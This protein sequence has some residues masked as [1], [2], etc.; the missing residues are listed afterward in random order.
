MFSYWRPPEQNQGVGIAFT[1]RFGGFSRGT[2]A[3]LNL[4]RTDVDDP[5][6]VAAS[7]RE[8]TAAIGVDHV[9]TARQTHSTIVYP[10]A[11]PQDWPP[12]AELGSSLPGGRRLPEADALIT[13]APGV[14][15]CIRVADCVP[16]LLADSQARV[17]AA[18]HAGRVGLVAGV[19]EAT[20]D[21]LEQAGAR[22]VS[23]W[24][25]PH[26]CGR[27]YEVPSE[28]AEQVAARVPATRSRTREGTASLDLG[29]GCVAILR[30]RQVEV[31]DVG[32][33]T[34]E[35][36]DLHSH[37]RDGAGAGR[38]AGLVWLG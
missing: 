6:A 24:I 23:A 8:V 29:A 28:M 30:S 34:L 16:V 7:F 31:R 19:L 10:V 36:P 5:A 17:V 25:G 26:V 13:R 2:F 33:C 1:D 38:L 20:L 32:R 3:E 4:G 11:G 18:A 37:R 9:A 35:S 14:A 22:Q 12:G 27:C 15:L 21:A